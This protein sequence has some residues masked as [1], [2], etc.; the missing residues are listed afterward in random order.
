MK[1]SM[2]KL[3]GQ[4][5]KQ[6]LPTHVP[7]EQPAAGNVAPRAS[8]ADPASEAGRVAAP[9]AARQQS[10][11]NIQ[12][13]GSRQKSEQKGDGASSS[14]MSQSGPYGSLLDKEAQRIA[15]FERILSAPIVDLVALRD[16]SWSG[17][18]AQFR[19]MAW[20]Q[21]LGYLPAN[22]E[23]RAATLQRKRR[24]YSE[25]VPQY[26]DVDDSERSEYQR[27]ILHQVSA[28]SSQV[29]S[30]RQPRST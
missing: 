15:K 20:Q 5:I 24:E 14:G 3:P 19:M 18:P 2:S 4:V 26:F 1:L 29:S 10:S 25:A 11:Q 7:A 21:L 30:H 13:L 12:S 9:P 28:E 6:L 16:A 17:I 23:W 8:D 22:S 27:A